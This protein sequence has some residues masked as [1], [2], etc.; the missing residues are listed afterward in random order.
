MSLRT[1][2][3]SDPQFQ[4]RP[5]RARCKTGC[6]CC[7]LRKKKCD[8]RKPVCTGCSK[9]GLTCSWL[10]SEEF[11]WRV[12]MGLSRNIDVG[13]SLDRE[14]PPPAPSRGL[15]PPEVAGSISQRLLQRYVE[16]ITPFLLTVPVGSPN[17]FVGDVLPLAFSD[18]LVMNAVLAVGGSVVMTIGADKTEEER[19]LQCYGEAIRGLKS[20]LA[21]WIAGSLGESECVRLFLTIILLAVYEVS[22]TS[23]VINIHPC[24]YKFLGGNG[25][26]L[27]YKLLT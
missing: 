11:A 17:P 7:R 2:S 24:G 9:L 27:L 26:F 21:D 8:E 20:K 16:Q 25:I 13:S 12:R 19:I 3:S 5:R 22:S 14:N 23:R 1:Q 15:T 10:E 4:L 6:I 18:V